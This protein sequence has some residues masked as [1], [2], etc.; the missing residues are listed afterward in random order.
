MATTRYAAPAETTD[1]CAERSTQIDNSGPE[2][3][4]RK[5]KDERPWEESAHVAD[6]RAA[7]FLGTTVA[8]LRKWRCRGVGPRWRKFGHLVRYST[9][10][11][12]RWA[13]EQERASTSADAA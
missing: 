9:A 12:E 5:S 10:D 11:L 6:E 13:A 4:K 7:E 3:S 2:K 8:T 1:R